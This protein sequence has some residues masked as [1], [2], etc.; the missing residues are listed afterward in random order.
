MRIKLTHGHPPREVW[1]KECPVCGMN[2]L[3]M[4]KNAWYV[5]GYE[6]G[7][8]VYTRTNGSTIPTRRILRSVHM[9]CCSK[10]CAEMALIQNM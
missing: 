8:G 5:S 9:W 1:E 4:F 2:K 10:P 7:D 3:E 6:A